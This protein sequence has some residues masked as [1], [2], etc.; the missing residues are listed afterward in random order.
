MSQ[1]SAN[2]QR[3][4]EAFAAN[5]G[6]V[7]QQASDNSYGFVLSEAGVL[8]FVP[9]QD[10]ARIIICLAQDRNK[11]PPSAYDNLLQLAGPYLPLGIL[12]HTAIGENGSA[13]LAAS[14]E[15]AD[16][17]LQRLDQTIAVLMELF[18]ENLS[19]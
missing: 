7:A 13:V 17:T 14:I 2:S 5:L 4:F 10:G 3:I 8:S 12:L 6:L 9:S 18:S 16:F 19:A 1:F 15:E 11:L